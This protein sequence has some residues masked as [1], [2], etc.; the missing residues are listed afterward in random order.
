MFVYCWIDAKLFPP[1]L[2]FTIVQNRYI[3]LVSLGV[4]DYPWEIDGLD[5]VTGLNKSRNPFHHYY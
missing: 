3:F 1:I 2:M 5:L 4:N